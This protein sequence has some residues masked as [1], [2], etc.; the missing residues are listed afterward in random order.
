MEP[1]WPERKE[2]LGL[3]RLGQNSCLIWILID[4][5]IEVDWLSMK[6]EKHSPPDQPARRA[7]NRVAI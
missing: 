3:G 7:L 6:N 4:V 2:A 5:D 1:V